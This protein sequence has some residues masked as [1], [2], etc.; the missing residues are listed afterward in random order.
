MAE[1]DEKAT[2]IVGG[3][4][5]E[6]WE[7]VWVQKTWGD[8]FH[9]FRFTC[10]ERDEA[11]KQLKPEDECEI[12]LAGELAITGMILTRQAAYDENS[13]G[14]MLQGVSNSWAAA[15]SS[16]IHET[17]SFDGKTFMQIAEEVLEKTGVKGTKKGTI[18]ETKFDRMHTHIGETIFQFL[19]RIAKERKIIVTADKDGNFLFVGENYSGE[20]IGALVEG[21]NI[22][23][24]NAVLSVSAQRSEFL[25]NSSTAATD[26]QHG[27]KAS[28]QQAKEKSKGLKRYSVL[29]VPNEQPVWTEDEVKKRLKNERMWTEAQQVQATIVVQGWK[30]G[31]GKLW[32]PGQQVSVKSK[33]ALIDQ[34]L[35]IQSATYT[36]DDASGT[37]TTLVCVAPSG[38]NGSSEFI[39][40]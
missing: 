21:V 17:N 10:A 18:S 7:S 8:S 26:S 11:P 28:E 36:Q 1:Q 2:L 27:R 16:I 29:L 22:K 24:C 39:L 13:H 6:D 31:T 3:S 35:A 12:E 32:E 25:V 37:L 30:A 4:K 33:M 23:R 15:R 40:S 34:E 20:Q 5:F 38:L 19:E 14:V 9:Q